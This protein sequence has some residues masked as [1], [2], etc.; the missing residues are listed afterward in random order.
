MKTV[1]ALEIVAALPSLGR[2]W[3]SPRRRRR[4]HLRKVGDYFRQ[5]GGIGQA[6]RAPLAWRS[7][8]GTAISRF[9]VTDGH[10]HDQSL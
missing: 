10:V 6:S 9:P 5:R 3:S 4:A 2:G 8:A 1:R 7:I